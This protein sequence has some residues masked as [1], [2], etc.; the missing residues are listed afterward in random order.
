MMTSFDNNED[1]ICLLLKDD[2]SGLHVRS[3]A[4]SHDL[5]FGDHGI[6]IAFLFGMSS[7]KQF[8]YLKNYFATR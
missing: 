6:T 2:V 5:K 7:N 4:R 1:K 3:R 8:N